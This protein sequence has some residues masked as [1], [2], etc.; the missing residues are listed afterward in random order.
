MA[1]GGV[2][3][4]PRARR[5]DLATWTAAA[6]VND[7]LSD[8]A[9]FTAAQAPFTCTAAA[10]MAL[11]PIVVSLSKNSRGVFD[12]SIPMS[13]MLAELLK[14]GI[15]TTLLV[16]QRVKSARGGR[17]DDALLHK[18]AA[19]EFVMFMI[20]GLIYFVNNNLLFYILQARE[21]PRRRAAPRRAAHPRRVVR[22]RSTRRR[23]SCSLR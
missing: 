17:A 3:S 15:S 7:A 13:N 8:A 19:Q 22:R 10:L 21:P 23:S 18:H 20:P 9:M 5:R 11:Q 1:A 12:Y 4:T 14:L 6:E 2:S 16:I